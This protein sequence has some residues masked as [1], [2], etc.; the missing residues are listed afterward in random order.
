MIP[1]G[2]LKVLARARLRDAGAL[3]QASRYDAA[4]YLAGYAVETALKARIC[5]TLGW[6]EFPPGK[7]EDYRSFTVHKLDVLLTLSGYEARLRSRHAREWAIARQWD[8]TDRYPAIGTMTEPEARARVE[9]ARVL[10]GT[11]L[12]GL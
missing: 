10:L 8:P 12:R 11:L 5:R 3:M 7:A 6:A 2:D 4:A 9:T 1:A